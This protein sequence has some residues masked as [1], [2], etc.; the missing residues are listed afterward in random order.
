MLYEVIT[1]GKAAQYGVLIKGGEPLE[2]AQKINTVVFDKTGTLTKGQPEVTDFINL[3]SFDDSYLF[4]ILH[5]IE[6][7]SEHPLA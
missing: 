1:T 3:S 2:M 4:S 7:K 5:S 6:S